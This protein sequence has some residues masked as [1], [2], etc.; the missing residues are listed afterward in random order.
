MLFYMHKVCSECGIDNHVNINS[1]NFRFKNR[2]NPEPLPNWASIV[3]KYVTE[4]YLKYG[5]WS[6]W[7]IDEEDGQ[8]TTGTR[9]CP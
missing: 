9:Q 4:S 1:S 3:S 7:G 5:I 2:K 8:S 6:K